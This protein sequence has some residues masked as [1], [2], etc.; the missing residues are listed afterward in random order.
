MKLY[1]FADPHGNFGDDLNPWLWKKLA[2]SL[3]NEDEMELF[4][5]IGTLLNHR[6][7]SAPIKHVFGSGV[8]YGNLPERNGRLI[9]HA[10][11]GYESARLLGE[12]KRKVI[13]DAAILVRAVD[14]PRA[15]I[16]DKEYGFIPHTLSSQYYDWS[17]VCDDLGIH[18]VSAQW[19]VERVFREMT[20]CKVMVCEAMHGAIIAD[21]LRIPWIPAVCY[22]YISAFKWGD[23][24][25]TLDLPYQP[26]VITSLYDPERNSLPVP[27]LKNK[28][29]RGFARI[30]IAP[31]NWT[32]PP[33]AKTGMKERARA[34]LELKAA[35][36]RPPQLSKDSIIE[37][38]TNRYLDLLDQFSRTHPII[39]KT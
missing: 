2:P 24:L 33:P 21:A 23:W 9:I 30:G 28:V 17:G 25:S 29:K 12:D 34:T 4:I 7:P 38:H 20:R 6:L 3:M 39:Q 19:N 22:D 31:T 15:P 13:T 36:N 35:L 10:L 27:R 8:G 5:G 37:S 1:Y 26:S 18:H 14:Y 11:R 16:K 32:E